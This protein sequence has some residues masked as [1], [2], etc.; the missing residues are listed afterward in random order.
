M[1]GAVADGV[2]IAPYASPPGLDYA[3]GRIW[4]GAQD[5]SVQCIARVDICISDDDPHAARQAVKPMI[6]LPLWNSYPHFAYLRPLGLEV[7]AALCQQ[8]ARRDYRLITRSASLVP[9]SFVRHLAV[10]GSCAE[11]I[12]QLQDIA[13]MGLDQIT[14]HPIVLP[15]QTLPEAIRCFAQDVMPHVRA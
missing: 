3:L 11:V 4:E 15:G 12:A 13:A 2:M 9:D 8:L 7:P 5:R 6:V 1:A 14:M 10:A